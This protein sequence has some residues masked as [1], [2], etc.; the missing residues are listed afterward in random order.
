MADSNI[1]VSMVKV[2]Q[3]FFGG[4]DWRFEFTVSLMQRDWTFLIVIPNEIPEFDRETYARKAFSDLM[5]AFATE[6]K[7]FEKPISN[8]IHRSAVILGGTP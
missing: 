5:E 7:A 1:V 4:K 3:N 8:R 2:D 6:A